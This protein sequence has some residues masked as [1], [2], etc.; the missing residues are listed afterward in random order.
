MTKILIII[1]ENADEL[2]FAVKLQEIG[3]QRIRP[4]DYHF[5]FQA[6]IP[7]GI[8]IHVLNAFLKTSNCLWQVYYGYARYSNTFEG[9]I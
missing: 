5:D 6:N 2:F 4:G 8:N 7:N 1:P 9:M 3:L